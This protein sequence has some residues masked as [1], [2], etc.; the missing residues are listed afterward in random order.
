M[1]TIELTEQSVSLF[2]GETKTINFSTNSI[3]SPVVRSSD[4]NIAIAVVKNNSITIRAIKP[5]SGATQS[6]VT[7]SLSFL[8]GENGFLPGISFKVIVKRKVRYGYCINKSESDPY[9]RVEYLYDAANLSPAYMDFENNVFNYGD[10]ENSWFITDNKPCMLKYDGTV[11]HY[12][13]PNDYTLKKDGTNSDIANPHYNGNAMAQIPL[14]WVYRYED[15]N[16][17]YTIIK[18]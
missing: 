2:I 9:E 3:G 12:L 10:W 16:Y 13:N 7:I 1:T 5:Q 14:V 8:D 15:N 6:E 17:L 11:D 4:D 18:E